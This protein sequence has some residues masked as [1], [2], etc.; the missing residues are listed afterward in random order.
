MLLAMGLSTTALSALILF[1]FFSYS[2]AANVRLP[3]YPLAVKS[4]YLSTWVPGNQLLDAATAQPEFWTGQSLT[5]TILARV[6]GTTY[7]LFGAP[8]GITGTTAAT[9]NSVS[10]TSLHTIISLTAGQAAITLD[11][12]SPVFPSP[13]DY[14]KH[15]LP[16]SYLTVNASSTES[17]EQRVQI[18]TAIDHTWTAQSGAAELNFTTSGAAGFFWFYN[19]DAIAYSENEDQATYGSVLF[20]TTTGTSMTYSCN[21][22]E[23]IYSQFVNKG[24]LTAVTTCSGLN[25]A[26]LAVDLGIVPGAASSATFAVGI[27]RDKAINYLGAQQTGVYR[28]KWH[29]VPLAIAFFLENYESA[30]ISSLAFDATVRSRS[31]AVSS[32]WGC[33]YADILEASIRQTFAALELTVG[34]N[35]IS[36]DY[37]L[38]QHHSSQVPVNDLAANPSAF[39]KEISSDGNINTVDL[40]YQS[41]PI[42]ISL[43]PEYIKLLFQPILTYLASGDFPHPYVLHDLGTR[44]FPL[45]LLWNVRFGPDDFKVRLVR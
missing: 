15:S 12:L 16:Y 10:Y 29:R 40:I 11:F 17:T 36:S 32:T 33:Q 21:T 26:A 4:P 3:S 45:S 13:D 41:W 28:T 24:H 37:R 18:L 39:L 43:N 7:T 8:A 42:F 23:T 14:A 31:E 19:K 20:G 1:T 9:T 6:G 25:L 27:N 5:W 2:F 44:E 30:Y 34:L 22:P 38:H 35:A